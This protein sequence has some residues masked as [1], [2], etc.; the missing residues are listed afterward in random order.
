[1]ID[2][3]N[4]LLPGLDDGPADD[5]G[6]IEMARAAVF[7]GLTGVVATPHVRED[8]PK[9]D[10]AAIAYAVGATQ[11]QLG[12]AGI[13]LAVV[14][15]AE[16]AL[17]PATTLED[18]E[19]RAL[20]LAGRGTLLLETPHGPL[21]SIFEDVVENLIERRGFRVLLAHPE[22][23]PDL[24]DDPSRLGALVAM[25]ALVQ[26]TATSLEP[27]GRAAHRRLAR[28]ALDRGWANVVA[29]DAHSATWRPPDMAPAREAGG[30]NFRWLTQ[31]VPR[32]LLLGAPIPERPF[33][34]PAEKR[35]R[36]RRR[37]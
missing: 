33:P 14:G 29:S 17:G 35:S 7:C 19:L 20:T 31:H 25:G 28:T 2:V 22:L 1:V 18:D 6:T 24:Q 21:P 4:H 32:A 34:P 16:V 3:H 30:V 23:N 10:A 15:G 13:Q 8:Y 36:W 9:V 12:A 5:L 11:A 37:G 27:G 26:L